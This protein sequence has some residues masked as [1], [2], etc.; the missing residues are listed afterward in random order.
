MFYFPSD[1]A[2]KTDEMTPNPRCS[3]RAFVVMIAAF[4]AVAVATAARAADVKPTRATK[5][6]ATTRATTTRQTN[7]DASATPTSTAS[8]AA[9]PSS[10]SIPDDRSDWSATMNTLGTLLAGHDLPALQRML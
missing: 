7:A 1:Q 8:T 6:A 4:T 2:D 5:P 9:A 3:W 10:A